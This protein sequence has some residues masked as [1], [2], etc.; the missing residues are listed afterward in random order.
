ML[1]V[2]I[3][4]TD[5]V[6]KRFEAMPAKVRA[7]LLLKVYSLTLRLE[8]HVKNDKLSGQVLKTQSGR[9]KRSIQSL[10]VD[11]PLLITGKVYSSGDVPYAAI[12]E[13]GGRTPPH[14][15]EP[16]KGKAL[17]FM[18]GGKQVFFRKVNH[19]GSVMPQRS[20]MRSSVNDMRTVI[21][22]EMTRAVREAVKS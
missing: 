2:K 21:I 16:V 8:A 17:A 18:M 1:S 7:A 6:A 13:Y 19:P 20:F 9:L 14:V 15:I 12:H 11:T 5:S 10:V 4:G 3:T 22:D